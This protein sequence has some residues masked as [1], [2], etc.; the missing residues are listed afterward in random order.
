MTTT[1]IATQPRSVGELVDEQVRRWELPRRAAASQGL[2]RRDAKRWVT[3]MESERRAFIRKHFH[4]E[5]LDPCNYDL[6]LNTAGL[7]RGAVL[8]SIQA[9]WECRS[10]KS[11]AVDRAP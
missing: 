9:A 2:T 8:A 11:P 4:A 1:K 10:R 5:I 3:R 6:V 7:G